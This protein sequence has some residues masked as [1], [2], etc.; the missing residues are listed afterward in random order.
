MHQDKI[1]SFLNTPLLL[2]LFNALRQH[3]FPNYLIGG[4]VRDCILS[5]KTKDI[6]IV[7][8]EDSGILAKDIANKLGVT[9]V[10]TYKNFGTAMFIYKGIDIE[11]VTARKESYTASSRNPTVEKGTLEDDQKRR[12]FT[13][14]S[15]S[16]SLNDDSYGALVDP[17]NGIEHLEQKRIKTP[18]DPNVTFN[19]DPLRMLRAI[20]FASQLNYTIDNESLDAIKQLSNR[21][22]IIS[23]ERINSEL[24]KIILSNTPSKGLY[25]LDKVG[26]LSIILP[27]LV[28]LKG[29]EYKNN[30]GHKDNFIHTLQVLDNIS[31]KSNNLWLR[32]AAILHDIAKPPTK[33]FNN[34]QGWTF[35]GHEDLGAR[36]VPRIFKNLKLP[37]DNKMKFV[38]KMVRLHLRPIALT[39]EEIS[40]S[41]LRRILFDAGEHIEELMTLCEADITS[42][43][44]QKV[45][46]YLQR[47]SIVRQKLK[48]VEERDQIRN[49]QPP[50]TGEEIMKELNIKPSKAIGT[51]KTAI[52]DAILDGKIENSKHAAMALM[53]EKAKELNILT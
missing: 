53:F 45:T 51:I 49:W 37:L 30:I 28:Q 41:A 20:R 38:Q 25:L 44:K 21:I 43:N 50:I 13:I 34:R 10:V 19:D 1:N 4:C 7:T 6:D 36:M 3:T 2:P 5:R 8:V 24:N 22:N 47:F 18:L 33:R 35:H 39:K 14:N 48:D 52:K 12:D 31:L 15:L 26:L 27:E 42:K 29:V 40:D 23:K 32:W 46:R 17:F 11:F 9:K 16:I